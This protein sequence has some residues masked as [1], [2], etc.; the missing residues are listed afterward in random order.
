MLF[1]SVAATLVAAVLTG[2]YRGDASHTGTYRTTVPGHYFAGLQWRYQS[3]GAVRSS[4]VVA[5]GVL[6]VG[7]SDGYVY[8][9]D[10]QSGT[11]RW[12][13]N[14]GS[15]VT[16]SPALDERSLIFE[17]HDGVVHAIDRITGTPRWSVRTGKELP[18]PW[19]HESGDFWSASPTLA[20][21]RVYIGSGDGYLYALDAA[22]GKQIWK[23]PTGGRIRSAPAV[24]D[25]TAYIGSFDG[26]LYAF[27]ARTGALRWKF[28]TE[29]AHLRSGDFGYDRRSIE[30]SPAVHGSEVFF[31]SK[32]G[33]LYAV[34]ARTGTLRWRKPANVYWYLSAPA[35]DRDLVFSGNSDGRFVQAVDAATGRTAWQFNTG[36]NVF[37]SPTVANGLVYA[38]AW[39]GKLYALDEASGRRLWAFDTFGRRIFSSVAVSQNRVYFGADDGGIY[40]LN[41]SPQQTFDKAVFYDPQLSG[42]TTVKNAKDVRDFLVARGYGELDAQS[43]KGYLASHATSRQRSVVVFAMDVLPTQLTE[44]GAQS[45]FRRYLNAGGKVVWIGA[46]PL[47]FGGKPIAQVQ[48]ADL[49]RTRPH[50]LI[51]VSYERGTFDP[52]TAFVTHD[53][54]AWGLAG[55]WLSAWPADPESVTS[56][57]ARDEQGL[58]ACWVRNYG[59]PPGTGFV[60]I[61][62]IASPQGVAWNLFSIDVAAQYFPE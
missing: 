45:A 15:A 38:G 20:L 31:G 12:R 37:A 53:G 19:G 10:A 6:Y 60:Q 42:Y 27:N 33:A 61:P 55:S 62:L 13:F 44:G 35:V 8:A 57:L 52:M 14:A 18:L 50:D 29:G 5:N 43:V 34:D 58:A 17:S 56:V 7:S 2:M 1:V 59:G 24:T 9:I 4:P 51:G 25:D 11:L 3:A 41:T 26:N 30:S 22:T 46:P 49:D 36:I 54:Q 39:D 47:L 23:T 32:D 28:A 16:S 40:A 48:I 21:G